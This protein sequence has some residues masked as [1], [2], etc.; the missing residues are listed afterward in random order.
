MPKGF[1]INNNQ[2]LNGGCYLFYDSVS[3]ATSYTGGM[4]FLPGAKEGRLSIISSLTFASD[5]SIYAWFL[6]QEIP[7]YHEVLIGTAPTGDKYFYTSFN[8]ELP[9]FQLYITTTIAQTW[10]IYL[11]VL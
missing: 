4:L 2:I 8:F 3:S 1:S 7:D 10:Y 11:Y 6:M 9:M 5:L